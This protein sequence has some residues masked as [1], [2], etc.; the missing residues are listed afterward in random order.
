MST[1]RGRTCTDGVPGQATFHTGHAAARDWVYYGDPR[2]AG[3]GRPLLRALAVCPSHHGFSSTPR[4]GRVALVL[5]TALYATHGARARRA[6]HSIHRQLFRNGE[7]PRGRRPRQEAVPNRT[8]C[9]L[10]KSI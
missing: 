4:C 7:V 9:R 8:L 6:F 10:E 5:R 1:A 3:E 2:V